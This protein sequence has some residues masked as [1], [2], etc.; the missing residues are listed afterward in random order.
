MLTRGLPNST[1]DAYQIIKK[2]SDAPKITP[3]MDLKRDLGLDSITIYMII[4]EIENHYSIQMP[5]NN[6]YM[7][8]Q[9][10]IL[11]TSTAINERNKRLKDFMGTRDNLSR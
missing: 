3:N 4:Y 11:A 5:D 8:V 7:T 9:D 2:H 6:N 10:I 1:D